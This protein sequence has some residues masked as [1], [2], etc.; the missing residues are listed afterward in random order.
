MASRADFKLSNTRA[1]G[2]DDARH[3]TVLDW[4]WNALAQA[5]VGLVVATTLVAISG[6]LRAFGIHKLGR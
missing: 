6:A 5:W 4:F 2:T 1:H 3:V